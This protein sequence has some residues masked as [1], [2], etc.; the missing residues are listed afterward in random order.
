MISQDFWQERLFG[1]SEILSA[2]ILVMVLVL[3]AAIVGMGQEERQI[4]AAQ[5]GSSYGLVNASDC[6]AD[7]L[8]RNHCL[9]QRTVA[10]DLYGK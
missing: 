10:A 6:A 1:A 3:G 9:A 8:D 2:W 4:A 5:G 7:A